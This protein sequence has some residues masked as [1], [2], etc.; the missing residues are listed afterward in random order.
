VFQKIADSLFYPY[1]GQILK[2]GSTLHKER[3]EYQANLDSKHD[4]GDTDA[5]VGVPAESPKEISQE[6]LFAVPDYMQ[7]DILQERFHTLFEKKH[8][9]LLEKQQQNNR[10]R[11]TIKAERK[12]RRW[13]LLCVLWDISKPTY[14][15]AGYYQLLIVL[16]QAFTPLAVRHLLKLI[17]TY[18]NESIFKQGIGFAIILFLSS[19]VDGIAQ[20]RTKFLAFQAGITIRAATVSSIYHHMLNL[21]SKGKQHLLTGETTNLVAIDCQKLFEVCQEGHLIW[22]CPLSMVIVTVLLVLTLGPATLVGMAS[23]FL[24]VPIVKKVVGRMMVIRRR[25]AVHT[26]KRVDTTSAMLTAMKFCKLNHYEEKFLKRVHDARRE[27]M[28]WVR[29]ELAYIG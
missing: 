27:E 8:A 15:Y 10:G 24:L 19:I 20:E 21:T 13:A 26:D 6:D 25:R 23:M 4:E 12:A 11:G 3:M 18:P 5:L 29:K 28:V 17:E 1:M 22:S 2:K 14:L 16:V 7:A 9:D